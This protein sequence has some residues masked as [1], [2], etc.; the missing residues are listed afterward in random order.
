MEPGR[1]LLHYRLVD[2]IGEGGMGVVWRAMDTTLDRDVA[3]K[4]LPD[5]FSR[6]PER[7]VRFEREAKLLGSLNHPNIATVHGLHQA[8]ASDEG[9]E[10]R[11]LAMELVEGEDLAARLGRGPLPVEEATAIAVQIAAALEAAHSQ[12]VV[13]RDLKPANIVLTSK[14]RAKVLDFGLAKAVE[15]DAASASG[16]LSLSPTITSMGTEAGVILGTAAYMSPEQARG[17]PVDRR[18]DLWSFGCV[19]YEC[20]TGVQIFRGETVSDSLAAILRKD[21]DWSALPADTPPLLRLLVRRCLTRDPG[22]RLQDAGD[23]RVELEQVLEDPGGSALGIISSGATAEATERGRPWLPWALAAVAVAAAGFF[24]LR[25]VADP[26]GPPISHRLMIPVPGHTEFGD[27]RSAP[28]VLSPDGRTVVFGITAETGET[29]LWA[30]SLDAFTTRP[31]PNTRNA[32]FVFWSP[33][34]REVG[35]FDTGKIKRIEVSTGRIQTIGGE[36]SAFPRGGSWNDAGQILYVP[37]S[38]S[39]VYLVEGDGQVRQITAPDPDVP[40]YSHRWPFFLPDGEHFLFT[41]W[42]NDLRVRAKHAGVFMASISGDAEP[43]RVIPDASSAA[44]AAPGY[45]LVVRDGNLIAVPFDPDARRVTGEAKVIASGVLHNSNNG[46]GAFSAS[47]EGT[48]VYA[49]GTALQPATLTW[50]G[51]DGVSSEAPG[52]PAPYHNV[53]LAPS[54]T[55]AAAMIPGESGDGQIWMMDLERGVRTRIDNTA[56]SRDNPIWSGDGDRLLYNS[57]Q[58]GIMDLEATRADGS[59][60]RESIFE[61]DRDKVP[62][63]WSRDGKHVAYW[64]L[65][66]ATGTANIWI[67]SVEDGTT[68]PLMEGEATYK[69]ARFSPDSRWISYVSD[70]STR[71]EV[72]VQALSMDDGVRGGARW[73]LSTSG[74]T[75]PHWR[76][77]GREIVYLDLERRVMAVPVEPRGDRLAL[78]TPQELFRVEGLI[79]SFDA[80]ADHQRFLVATRAGIGSEPLRVVLNWTADLD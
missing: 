5:Q 11:F 58:N 19:L 53:R 6:D 50:Y 2:K 57:Q 77:D 59:G 15:P 68:A 48:L 27:F 43:E 3:I 8:T 71:M 20:L 63:D 75:L 22:K 9:S 80:A 34:S 51:R 12:G 73:Q 52:E 56:W 1:N 17:R 64:T 70:D 62:Y 7:L 55:S 74:G 28:P 14:G 40:D 23:A 78:G 4:V 79:V 18:A 76:D 38:N 31:L 10:V 32:A 41:A 37:D 30:R 33:D 47:D 35:Y 72:F 66:D 16:G 67:Y 69:D 26:T 60:G 61:D 46:Y 21:P 13:H 36:S 24:A 29:R 65:G 25:G 42:T 54:G 49:R 39:G 45:L 44:F